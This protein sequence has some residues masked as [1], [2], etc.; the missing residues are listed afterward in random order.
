MAEAEGELPTRTGR[1]NAVIKDIKKIPTPTIDSDTL[2]SILNKNGIELKSLT[3][4][5]FN[6]ILNGIR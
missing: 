5:E 1:L 3:Q 2:V 6:Y 4:K